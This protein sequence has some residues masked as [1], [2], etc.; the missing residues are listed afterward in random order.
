MDPLT[1]NI[2]LVFLVTTMMA[3]G[4]KTTPAELVAALASRSLIIRSL[5]VNIII[6]PL[7]GLLLVKIIPMST[8]TAVS[9]LLLA[10]APGGLNAIQ[11]TSKSKDALCYAASLLFIL[12]LL[13]IL[14]SPVIIALMIPL[15]TPLALPYRTVFSFLLLY[16]LLPLTA[17]LAVHRISKRFANLLSKPMALCG[18]VAFIT[19]VVRMM[20]LRKEAMAALGKSELLAMLGFIVAMMIIAWFLGGP[21]LETRRVLATATSMRNAALC[22][23]I[24]LNG[25]PDSGVIAAVVAFSGLMIPPNMLLTVYSIIKERKTSETKYDRE[26]FTK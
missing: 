25:F 26:C 8:D 3:I 6:A 11:F 4:I 2:A 24:A 19:V 22:F 20:T 12:S 5:V 23:I 9:I 17:G 1:K 14:L 13:A 15:R 18:T 10:A 7:L 16:L 21:S